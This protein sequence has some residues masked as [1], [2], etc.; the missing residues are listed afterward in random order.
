MSPWRGLVWWAAAL[1]LLPLLLP[2]AV[3]ARRTA[4]RLAPAAGAAQGLAATAE[5]SGTPLRLL[6]LG[7]S[8]VA[9]VGAACLEQALAGQLAVALARRLARPVQWQAL[10]ENG[11]TAGEACR[12]LLPQVG[13]RFDLVVLVFG[14][15]DTTHFTSAAA[16]RAALARLIERF[17]G[18]GAAVLCTGVPPLEH[19]HA[20]PWLLRQ[21]LGWRARLL[22][23]QLRAQAQDS[24]ARY[25]GLSLAM[26]REF[27]AIDGYHPSTLGYRVWAEG[28]A[29]VAAA[30]YPGR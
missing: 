25:C 23:A 16:W 5:Q 4:L 2:L 3:H 27:L 12:R 11:I 22:D 28:L 6:V 21:L 19:F 18:Q 1:P 26:R 24:G 29:E 17:R 10:G 20:L 9:G 7:E 14:V 13:E 30:L 15:N 8:T